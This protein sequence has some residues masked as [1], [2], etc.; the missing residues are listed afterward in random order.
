[1]FNQY[2][3]YRLLKLRK[4]EIERNVQNTWIHYNNGTEINE[5]KKI[6]VKSPLAIMP[7]CECTC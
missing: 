5:C 1:M 6:D 3:E 2:A 4:E 7:C